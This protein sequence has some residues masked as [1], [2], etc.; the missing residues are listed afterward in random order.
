LGLTVISETASDQHVHHDLSDRV[1]F[2][3]INDIPAMVEAIKIELL[4]SPT[5]LPQVR[6]HLSEKGMK[7]KAALE[8]LG[9]T[10]THKLS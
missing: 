8:S 6:D 7:L 5:L 2:T 4:R 3:P 9:I 10:L 1:I